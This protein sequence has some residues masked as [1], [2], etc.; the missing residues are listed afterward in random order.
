MMLSGGAHLG[1]RLHQEIDRDD[2]TGFGPAPACAGLLACA[3]RGG[4]G[5]DQQIS[6]ARDPRLATIEVPVGNQ[7]GRGRIVGELKQ[8]NPGG[9]KAGRTPPGE[10]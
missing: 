8:L 10:R 6:D 5:R 1:E 4:A 9:K 3:R 7:G 2:T